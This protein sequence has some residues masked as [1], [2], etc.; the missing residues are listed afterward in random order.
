MSDAEA[1]GVVTQGRGADDQAVVLGISNRWWMSR[2]AF[3][4]V[5]EVVSPIINNKAAGMCEH[6]CD[7]VRFR[8]VIQLGSL[9]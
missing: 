3:V 6:E 7:A 2:I 8:V 4:R 5:N 1:W 9:S